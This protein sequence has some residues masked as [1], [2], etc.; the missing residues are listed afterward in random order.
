MRTHSC[1]G[2]YLNCNDMSGSDVFRCGAKLY[3]TMVVFLFFSAL[4][5]DS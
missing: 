5:A 2:L 4:A 3:F 1:G